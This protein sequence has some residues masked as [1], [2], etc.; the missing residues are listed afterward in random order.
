[1]L[2][3]KSA[4][5]QRLVTDWEHSLDGLAE[6][7]RGP[8][9]PGLSAGELAHHRIYRAYRL[10]ARG[11]AALS[12]ESPAEDLHALRKRCK[13][14][15]YALEVFAPVIDKDS[16]KAAVS[17][18]KELQDVLGRFQDSEVQR[19]SLRE[20]AHVMMAD[21]TSVEAVLAMGELVGHLDAEQDRAR[22]DFAGAFARFVRPAS[23][24]RL[25]SLGGKQ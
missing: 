23:H 17:D 12:A 15:R 18:L 5:F 7:S 22:H 10:V 16:R 6:K 19:Q 8:A 14:L 2:G 25:R 1:M 11:G 4:R 24:R 20:F 21:G 3:L 13:E 9:A